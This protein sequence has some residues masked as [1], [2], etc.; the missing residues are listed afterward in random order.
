MAMRGWA[1]PIVVGVCLLAAVACSTSGPARENPRPEYRPTSTVKD[2]MDSM[3]DPNADA[4]W[5][6]VAVTVS[7]A[8]TERKAPRTEDEW[9]EVRRHTIPILEAT[10][11]LLMPGRHVARP[12]EKA[13][14]PEIELEPEQIE[15]LIEQ[16]RQAFT[17]LAHGLHDAA[18][19]V[20]KAIE[21]RDAQA[22]LFAGDG[23][24]KACER[25]H[26]KYWYPPNKAAAAA[27]AGAVSRVTTK[28]AAEVAAMPQS[29][30]ITGHVRL[31][32]TLPGNPI[33]RMGVDP[34]CASVNAGASVVQETVMASA[35]GSLANVF[36]SLQ[37]SFAAT[38]VP[39]TPV[40]VEQQA[41]IYRP[42][43]VGVRVGQP[44]EFRNGDA[45]L[46]NVRSASSRGNE[47]NVGQPPAAPAFRFVPA[48]DELM[49]RVKCDIHSWMT[50]YVGVV[51]HPYF[52]VSGATGTFTIAN[53]PPGTHSIQAWHER[54]GVL[55]R[56]VEVKAGASATVDFSYSGR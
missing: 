39:S 41:C 15:A 19:V 21:A 34:K 30:T 16:D 9:I 47:F 20:L 50:T 2:I 55:T 8:G 1:G 37:G 46:H 3:V 24:D 13:E 4:I 32:G 18:S 33:I 23:L 27:S 29:G 38:P 22:L 44:L 52:A 53:V 25:C 36:V 40:I 5:D 54:Y 42:R 28:P 17:T 14:K 45:L 7:A 49:L 11:L 35:D 12:G 6:A 48:Q 10:N 26:L 51:S 31:Q 43:V 56:A